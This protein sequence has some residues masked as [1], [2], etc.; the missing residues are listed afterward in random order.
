V[1]KWPKEWHTQNIIG[2]GSSNLRPPFYWQP[3]WGWDVGAAT[4][5][6]KLGQDYKEICDAF[7]HESASA[8]IPIIDL[9]SEVCD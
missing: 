8:T 7:H 4:Q 1:G 5:R 3:L 6:A 2:L 9:S